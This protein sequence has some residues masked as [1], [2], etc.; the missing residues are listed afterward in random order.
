MNTRDG[1][2]G[3]RTATP[4]TRNWKLKLKDDY[5]GDLEDIGMRHV[6]AREQVD[7]FSH[8]LYP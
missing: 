5:T 6:E 1:C 4:M 7:R 2:K 3:L 8:M